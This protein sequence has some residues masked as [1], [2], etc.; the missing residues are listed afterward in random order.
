[1]NDSTTNDLT[2]IAGELEA[3]RQEL[4][5]GLERAERLLRTAGGDAARARA[6]AGWLVHVRM[7]LTREHQSRGGSLVTIDDTTPPA[8]THT[9]AQPLLGQLIRQ[10]RQDLGWTQQQLASRVGLRQEY[11]S[12]IE[13]GFH[14]PKDD[15]IRRIEAVMGYQPYDFGPHPGAG[16]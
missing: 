7:A 12:R 3:R 9:A 13:A 14:R 1:M 8:M 6:E 11:V 5:Q 10:A 16:L 2:E 4:L 15:S